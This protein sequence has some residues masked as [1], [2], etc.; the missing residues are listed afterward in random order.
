MAQVSNLTFTS[1]IKTMQRYGL[2]HCKG[3]ALSFKDFGSEVRAMRDVEQF[4]HQAEV[5]LDITE[6]DISKVIERMAKKVSQS[7]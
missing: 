5:M 6:D 4:V 2:L 3:E 1:P 7:T